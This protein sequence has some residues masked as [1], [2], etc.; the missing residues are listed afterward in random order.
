M[1]LQIEIR[2]WDPHWVN[3]LQ[4]NLTWEMHPWEREGVLHIPLRRVTEERHLED[5]FHFENMDGDIELELRWIPIL[6]GSA[7]GAAT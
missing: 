2:D 5:A 3:H 1:V 7:D 4:E 6:D